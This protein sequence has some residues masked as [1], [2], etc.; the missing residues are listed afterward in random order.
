MRGG[1][2][3]NLAKRGCG[4][5]IEK[6]TETAPFEKPNSKGCATR[7]EEKQAEHK[8]DWKQVKN[9]LHG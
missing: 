8:Q 5:K 2:A 3:E 4:R 1:K 6:K 7:G 9:A